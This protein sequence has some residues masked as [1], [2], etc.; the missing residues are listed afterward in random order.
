MG[1]DNINLKIPESVNHI[2]DS[3]YEGCNWHPAYKGQY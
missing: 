3:A 1:C 2:G